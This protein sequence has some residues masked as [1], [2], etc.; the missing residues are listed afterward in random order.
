MAREFS[1]VLHTGCPWRFALFLSH[2]SVKWR[3][4]LG[5]LLHVE[6]SGTR[7]ERFSLQLV[8]EDFIP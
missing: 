4:G 7:M 8:K 3:L 5:M 6:K 1:D 2:P